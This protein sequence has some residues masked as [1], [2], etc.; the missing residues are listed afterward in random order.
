VAGAVSDEA[1][2]LVDL[3]RQAHEVMGDL[4]RLI[5]EA[6]AVVDSIPKRAMDEVGDLLI[7]ASEKEL[8]AY[9]QGVE[10]SIQDAQQAIFDRFDSIA[11]IILNVSKRTIRQ[12]ETAE[13]AAQ[14]IR[15]I[16]EE[17]GF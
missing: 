17:R 4:R 7:A 6:Q 10:E 13:D 8:V 3:L 11:N 12:G 2:T 5:K 1:D 16:I 14:Q 9:H 15:K